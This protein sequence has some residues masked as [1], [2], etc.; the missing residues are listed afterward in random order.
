RWNLIPQRVSFD[1]VAVA[2]T[3]RLRVERDLKMFAHLFG[4]RPNI[5]QVYFSATCSLSERLISQVDI[6]ASRKRKRYYQRR[7]HQEIRLDA[8]MH[9][10]F[11]VAISAQHACANEIVLCYRFFNSRIE[12][13]RVADTS[14]ATVTDKVKAQLIQ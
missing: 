4:A 8:L 3:V 11:E 1:K 14:C 9:P 10:R 13:S 2:L 6:D 5:A 7:A 12:R